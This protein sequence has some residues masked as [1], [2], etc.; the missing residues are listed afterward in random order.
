[1]SVPNPI[2]VPLTVVSDA[3]SV[4]LGVNVTEPTSYNTLQNKPQ[5]NGVTLEGNCASEDLNL[6]DVSEMGSLG[7]LY[8]E[9]KSSIVNAINEVKNEASDAIQR[10]GNPV[11][12]TTQAKSD[13]VDAVNEVNGKTNTVY[14]VNYGDNDITVED[15]YAAVQ[16]GKSVL[17]RFPLTVYDGEASILVPL[18]QIDTMQGGAE[19][20]TVY[21]DNSNYLH[22]IRL[23]LYPENEGGGWEDFVNV[24]SPSNVGATEA[25]VSNAYRIRRYNGSL[26]TY[27]SLYK[28]SLCFTRYDGTLI[29]TAKSSSTGTSKNLTTEAFLPW[30]N[31]TYY[32]GNTTV[33][34]NGTVSADKLWLA[35]EL[36]LRYSFNTGSTLVSGKPVYVKCSPTYDGVG[37]KLSGNNCIVQDL[38]REDDGYV[39]IYLGIAYNTTSICLDLNHPVYRV[40]GRGNVSLYTGEYEE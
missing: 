3:E 9:D 28:Y 7:D 11:D 27:A 2:V 33:S 35:T 1:M 39:Y 30:A 22:R 20:S 26:K 18:T 32:S 40:D 36:D 24:V 17:C 38:P 23:V 10:C 13:L 14:I 31:I 29:P 15:I 34:A 5:I 6:V 16:A 25:Y 4:E 37:V 12:L 8:T 21:C 19:F